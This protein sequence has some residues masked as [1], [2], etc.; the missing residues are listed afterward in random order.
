MAGVIAMPAKRP[1]KAPPPPT[2]EQRAG[3]AEVAKLVAQSVKLEKIGMGKFAEL[4]PEEQSEA[5]RRG[6]RELAT[7]PIQPTRPR[8]PADKFLRATRQLSAAIKRQYLPP[9]STHP[10]L[11]EELRELNRELTK[12]LG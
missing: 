6:R 7:P 4:S 1:W 3:A 9:Q 12:L 5:M 11:W 8:P 10:V 2:P